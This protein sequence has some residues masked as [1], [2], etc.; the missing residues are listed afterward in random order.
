M[1]DTRGSP[2]ATKSVREGSVWTGTIVVR[3]LDVER[4]VWRYYS[5]GAT[6]SMI[7]I[8]VRK[9]VSTRVFG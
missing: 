3:Y 8:R 1:R 2:V 5:T 4:Y 9:V 7:G 6:M